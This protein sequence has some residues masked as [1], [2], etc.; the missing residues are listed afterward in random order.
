MSSY[1]LTYFDSKGRAEV[2]RYL[3]AKAQVSYEDVRI[4]KEDWPELKKKMPF[5]QVPILEVDGQ[6]ICQSYAIACFLARK[7]GLFGNGEMEEA[8]IH[9]VCLCMDDLVKPMFSFIF[10][11]DGEKKDTLKKKYEEQQ[12]PISMNY[13]SQILEM[14]NGGDGFFVGET[15]TLA[16]IYF[17][18]MTEAPEHLNVKINW[19]DFPKLKALREKVEADPGIAEWKEKRPKTTF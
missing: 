7:F 4:K 6:I 16:D 2:A 1:K 10:E 9:S 5:G 19:E 17:T 8:Q 12:L 3:F 15:M 11:Q 18:L 13:M 14:N